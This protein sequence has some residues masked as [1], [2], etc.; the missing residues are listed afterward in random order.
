MKRGLVFAFIVGLASLV[1]ASD[2]SVEV[3]LEDPAVAY[4][5]LVRSQRA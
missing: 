1:H 5:F 3:T 4:L 2:N